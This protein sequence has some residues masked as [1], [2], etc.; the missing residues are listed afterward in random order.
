MWS[1]VNQMKLNVVLKGFV[2]QL[3]DFQL[4]D[5]LKPRLPDNFFQNQMIL[6]KHRNMWKTFNKKGY[7]S[8]G[9]FINSQKVV[10]LSNISDRK[11]DKTAYKI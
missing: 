1:K 6:V 8:L 9:I 7:F 2:F 3:V 4:A 10:T 5:D 11:S